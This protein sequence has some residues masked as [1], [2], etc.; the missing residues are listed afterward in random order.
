MLSCERPHMGFKFD[1]ERLF[2]HF[3]NN[4]HSLP[5]FVPFVTYYFARFGTNF[6]RKFFVTF[7]TSFIPQTFLV[8]LS[9]FLLLLSRFLFVN[10]FCYFRNVFY[11]WFPPTKRR[12]TTK[13]FLGPLS[14]ARGQQGI[15]ISHRSIFCFRDRNL[16]PICPSEPVWNVHRT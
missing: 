16:W 4:F 14:V 8:L 7:F 15:A 9:H 2:C 6:V 13:T 11:S 12:R 3:K 1:R 5:F 10:V